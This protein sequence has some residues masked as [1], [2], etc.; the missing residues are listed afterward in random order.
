[1]PKSEND[2]TCKASEQLESSALELLLRSPRLTIDTIL[3]LLTIN[4]REFRCLVR[5]NPALGGLLKQRQQGLLQLPGTEPRKCPMCNDWFLPYGGSRLCSDACKTA[6]RIERR[7][8][9]EE[10]RTT[11]D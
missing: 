2:K 4:E 10:S 5:A 7:A 8:F 9:R 3:R 11:S 6:A 1:M